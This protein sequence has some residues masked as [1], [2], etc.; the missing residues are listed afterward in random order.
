[1]HDG[2]TVT[3]WMEQERDRRGNH[4]LLDTHLRGR[5]E[6][7]LTKDSLQRHRHSRTHRLHR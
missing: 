4:L 5:Q 6:G 3:D 7:C 1:V 2:E